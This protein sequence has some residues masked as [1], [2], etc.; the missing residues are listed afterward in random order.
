LDQK[1]PGKP[2]EVI[3]EQARYCSERFQ[4]SGMLTLTPDF[5]IF[6]PDLVDPTVNKNGV[7]QYQLYISMVDIF[8]CQMTREN[9]KYFYDTSLEISVLK[10]DS[11][12]MYDFLLEDRK[13]RFVHQKILG[14][15]SRE[16]HDTSE[17]EPNNPHSRLTHS[18]D[19]DRESIERETSLGEVLPQLRPPSVLLNDHLVQQ[20]AVNLPSRFRYCDW[21]LLY[22]TR[23]HGI[24]LNTLYSRCKDQGASIL[25]VEDNKANVFGGFVSDSWRV[26]PHYYGTGESFLFSL[27]PNVNFF[28]WTGKNN[29]I[30][31]S[32]RDFISIGGGSHFG[33]WID[34]D[35]FHGS[36]GRSETFGNPCLGTAEDF[37]VC[38]VEVWG[39]TDKV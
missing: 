36:S 18:E 7:L 15:T 11:V 29:F 16:Q 38:V 23:E 27:K 6:E 24:S 25:V 28:H 34:A 19:V 9:E 13:L 33:L 1:A 20:I 14:W 4:I 8:D 21:T 31:C 12:K 26:E 39:L 22:G 37:Q 17:P 10:D 30:M 32:R 3:K 35:F 2:I 5:F